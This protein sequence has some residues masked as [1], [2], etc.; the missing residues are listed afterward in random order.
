MPQSRY[1]ESHV[2]QNPLRKANSELPSLPKLVK[3]LGKGPTTLMPLVK[4]DNIV[5]KVWMPSLTP[6][7]CGPRVIVVIEFLDA[8]KNTL[9][10]SQLFFF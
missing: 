2:F 9:E 4:C 10:H 7:E 6:F 8:M 5:H 1:F 3:V